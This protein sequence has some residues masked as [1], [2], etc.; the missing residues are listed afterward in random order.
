MRHLNNNCSEEGCDS[1]KDSLKALELKEK[2]C[3]EEATE[4]SG[5]HHIEKGGEDTM[6]KR[7]SGRTTCVKKL[8]SVLSY[9]DEYFSVIAN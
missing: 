7:K 6:K 5:Q 1:V 9:Q 3:E 8:P 4:I 2:K